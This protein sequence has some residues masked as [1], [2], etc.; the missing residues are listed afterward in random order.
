MKAYINWPFGTKGHYHLPSSISPIMLDVLARRDASRNL[1]FIFLN[2]S[3]NVQGKPL[4]RKA[5][6]KLTNLREDEIINN[7]ESL[8]NTYLPEILP[9]AKKIADN[10]IIS[11][12]NIFNKLGTLKSGIYSKGKIAS[13]LNFRDDS[14]EARAFSQKAFTILWEEGLIYWNKNPEKPFFFVDMKKLTSKVPYSS[15]SKKLNIPKFAKKEL[16]NSYNVYKKDLPISNIS[17]YSTPL[18][19]KIR[20]KSIETFSDEEF[21][22]DPRLNDGKLVQPSVSLKPL[23][24]CYL[25]PLY[26]ES[27]LNSKI[28]NFTSCNDIRGITHFN[29]PQ[30]LFHHYF[31]SH[32]SEDYS[33]KILFNQLLVNE[34]NL[35][36]SFKGNLLLSIKDLTSEGPGMGRFI[37]LKNGVLGGGKR[38]F[39]NSRKQYYSL[40]KKVKEMKKKEFSIQDSRPVYS[41]L[42]KSEI[43]NFKLR[44]ESFL[45]K[46]GPPKALDFL[47]D[48][49]YGISRLEGTTA[50]L[51]AK[52]SLSAL[53]ELLVKID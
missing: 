38:K 6:M 28:T 37:A 30:I 36:Y 35:P 14:T 41:R 33:Q 27:S 52:S 19:L 31:K 43:N 16:K 10:N 17:G 8:V 22:V 47:I 12:K 24:N 25:V 7:Y 50:P 44:Y 3:W 11:S 9:I 5:L 53:E 2:E 18:P 21:P 48:Y 26:L 23:F 39:Q 34:K 29:F 20:K 1:D 4:D 45:Y 46:E 15:I 40:I 42:L 32:L 49:I 51:E 13:P